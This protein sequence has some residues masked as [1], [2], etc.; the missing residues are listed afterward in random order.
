MISIEIGV[1]MTKKY[2]TETKFI[3]SIHMGNISKCNIN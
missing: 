3:L 1:E 2:N